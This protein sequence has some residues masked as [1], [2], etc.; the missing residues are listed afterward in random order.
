MRTHL[1]LIIM[2]S[3]C[4]SKNGWNSS[5][6][7]DKMNIFWP[8]EI[9]L[10]VIIY[11]VVKKV[12]FLQSRTFCKQQYNIICVDD[13]CGILVTTLDL[14]LNWVGFTPTLASIFWS[15]DFFVK[16]IS[17]KLLYRSLIT[18]CSDIRLHSNVSPK[19]LMSN[20]SLHGLFA[21]S[22]TNSW[23]FFFSLCGWEV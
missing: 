13:L 19:Y 6:K 9:N 14:G 8:R 18:S 2:G 20:N 22:T 3:L 11:L 10:V 16:S 4:L 15:V 17:R 21:E 23:L 5:W 12:T 7:N 1:A